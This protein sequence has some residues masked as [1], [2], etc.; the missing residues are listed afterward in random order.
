MESGRKVR[1]DWRIAEFPHALPTWSLLYCL[2]FNIKAI[3]CKT[4]QKS[5]IGK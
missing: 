1:D 4:I 2:N 5:F 3:F